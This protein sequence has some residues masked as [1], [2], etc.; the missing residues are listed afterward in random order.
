[1]SP[2]FLLSMA[3]GYP[4]VLKQFIQF[5]LIIIYPGWVFVVIVGA[6]CMRCST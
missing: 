3:E 5:C 2:R 4:V 6:A 1:M